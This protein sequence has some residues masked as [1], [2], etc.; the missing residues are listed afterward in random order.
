MGIEFVGVPWG[1]GGFTSVPSKPACREG[2][3]P[4][5]VS[6]ADNR[7]HAYTKSLGHRAIEWIAEAGKEIRSRFADFR[8][9]CRSGNFFANVLVA[10][11]LGVP[12]KY[13]NELSKPFQLL[14]V[15]Y[16]RERVDVGLTEQAKIEI[17]NYVEK[18]EG[19]Q[20]YVVQTDG[21]QVE[22]K[23]FSARVVTIYTDMVQILS[24]KYTRK[25]IRESQP[26]F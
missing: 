17:K 3:K 16:R 12:Q 7:A 6:R 24:S 18:I 10:K 13:C 21:A 25:N 26:F 5:A 2:Q 1:G 9:R 19:I 22:T 8:E 4:R 11:M 14:E 20:R 23:E 15:S